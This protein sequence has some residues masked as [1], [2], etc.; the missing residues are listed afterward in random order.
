MPHRVPVTPQGRRAHPADRSDVRRHGRRVEGSRWGFRARKVAGPLIEA[1]RAEL[2]ESLP[3]REDF[4]ARGFDYQDA[5]LAAQRARLSEKARSGDP[6]A[7]GDLTKIK[8]RQR[9]L[10]AR[11]DE[12]LARLRA[13]PELIAADEVTFLAH[14]LVLPSS[15]PEDRRRHDAEVEA[16]AV[17]VAWGYEETRGAAVK[18]VSKGPLP[19]ACGLTECPGF[20]LLSKGPGTEERAI[21]V[22]GRAGV[23][24]HRADRERVGQV[25]QLAGAVLALRRLRLRN[26]DA[27]ARPRPGPVPEARCEREGRS[28]H[29][30]ER[31]HRC[32]RGQAVSWDE[33]LDGVAKRIAEIDLSPLRVL[34]G[35]GTGKTFALT[36]RVARLLESGAEP[37]RMLVCTFTR[38]I[39]ADLKKEIAAL[40][41]ED[42]DAVRA[43]TLHGFCF[44]LLSRGEVLALTGRKPRPLLKF[45][46]RFLLEDLKDSRFGGIR[47]CSRRLEAFNSAW[48]RLQS[49]EPGW[50]SDP[51]DRRFQAELKSWLLFHQAILVGEVV[52]ET[53]R[54]LR[55]N[56]S[57]ED[58]SAFEHVLVD[59]YQ[60][61]NR[62]EQVLLDLLAED[63]TL[64]VIGDENQSIYSFKFA[65]PEGIS[66]FHENHPGTHDETLD[67][68]RRCPALVIELANHL[69]SR[70]DTSVP[71]P[72]Q[73]TST[74]PPGEVFVVQW[75]SMRD[76]AR[77]LARFIPSRSNPALLP[78]ARS[79]FLRLD[80]SSA[81]EYE[82]SSRVWGHQRSASF[83]KKTSRGPERRVRKLGSSGVLSSFPTG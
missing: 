72:L 36:R 15:D 76:E 59:E 13:E 1:R 45:E 26:A 49:D 39:A 70:N 9:T 68:C 46:Q 61:L 58:R 35:P 67:E 51:V 5:E 69:I 37:S 48:A 27:A 50:P 52:P 14:A 43:G 83:T 53:L 33:N 25:L 40:G 2:L 12:A 81:T 73:P 57:S 17:R 60:D 23:G 18:D 66:R 42:I 56:P 24:R 16:I 77:G 32:R 19:L 11:R 21:E 31:D 71:R 54:Y 47:G 6:K 65:H 28:D 63:G 62:A 44:S 7:K 64:T 8:D 55:E 29:R 30:R 4:V 82:M 34:A 22:K 3:V 10:A 41:L 38:T 74:T 78:P 80:V 20:D 75:P 79:S